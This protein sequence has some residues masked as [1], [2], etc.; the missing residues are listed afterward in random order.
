MMFEA[1]ASHS[2][3]ETDNERQRGE[4]YVCMRAKNSYFEA[5][6]Y[7]FDAYMVW[8]AWMHSNLEIQI[9]C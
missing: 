1:I 7:R 4:A 2:H 5:Q 3:E 8:H 9:F 6:L